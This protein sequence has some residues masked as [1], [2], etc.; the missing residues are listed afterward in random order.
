MAVQ[1]LLSTGALLHL[2]VSPHWVRLM[3]PLAGKADLLAAPTAEILEDSLAP[4]AEILEVEVEVVLWLTALPAAAADLV[5][6]LQTILLPFLAATLA[7]FLAL[8][9]VALAFSTQFKLITPWALAVEVAHMSLTKWV[10]LA[11]LVLLAVAAVEVAQ[12]TA[13]AILVL[14]ATVAAV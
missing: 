14:A 6:P 4:T 1:E 5:A 12:V 2:T 11:V 9:T 7:T 10:A 3:A 8:Q 13:V